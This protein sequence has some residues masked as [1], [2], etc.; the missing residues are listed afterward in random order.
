M[1]HIARDSEDRAS[2]LAKMRL[3]SGLVWPIPITLDVTRDFAAGIQG[4]DRIGKRARNGAQRRL[5]QHDID[6]ATREPA[7][8]RIADVG[9]HCLDARVV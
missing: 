3:P 4:G 1:T 8:G 2:V 6:I 7:G 5:V 9:L